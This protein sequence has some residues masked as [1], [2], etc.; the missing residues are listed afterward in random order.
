MNLNGV[1]F[2]A[3]NV[4]VVTCDLPFQVGRAAVAGG[5]VVHRSGSGQSRDGN[6]VCGLPARRR[7]RGR[8]L[9]QL[10]PAG[11]EL[12]AT[13]IRDTALTFIIVRPPLFLPLNNFT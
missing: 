11:Q 7:G 8:V 2:P 12:L 1:G 6:R 13:H 4:P 3:V 10:H 5:L 9:Y